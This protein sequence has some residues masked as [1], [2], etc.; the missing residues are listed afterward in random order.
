MIYC[1]A[2]GSGGGGG[3]PEVSVVFP[4]YNEEEGIA[5]CVG[6]ALDA[7]RAAGLNGEVVVVDNASTDG[8]ASKAA[9]HGARVIHEARRGYGWAVRRGLSEASGETIVMLDADGTYPEE[10]IPEFVRRVREGGFDLVCGNRFGSAIEPRAMPW[11][12]RHIGNPVLSA[13]TRRFFHVPVRDIHCGMRAMRRGVVAAMRLRAPGMEL[14]TEMIVKAGDCKLRVG[15]IPIGYRSRIGTSK[16]RRFRD[17]WRH[18]EYML[19][20]VPTVFLLWPGLALLLSGWAIQVVLLAGPRDVFFRTWDVHTNL[21]GLAASL[22]GSTMI[23]LAIVNIALARL[24]GLSFGY[25][26]VARRIAAWGE[27]P[28]RAAGVIATLSGVVTWAVVMFRWVASGFGALS[29]ISVLSLATSL[30]VA[31]LGWLTAAFLVRMIRNCEG[32]EGGP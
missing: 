27:S 13:M 10:M 28:V 18:V 32:E 8:S 17:G 19:V 29:A 31:G 24:A 11:L 3:G 14:A 12:N 9:A 15:E 21:A 6:R 23:G 2:D 26:P 25:S 1:G 20:L 4:C 5:C 7:L 22:V 16:L 30:L